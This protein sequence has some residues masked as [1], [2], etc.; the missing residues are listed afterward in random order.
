[1]ALLE[2]CQRLLH[3]AVLSG[4]QLPAEPRERRR[5][6]VN[7]ITA[8][9]LGFN[10]LLYVP[11]L[12][13]LGYPGLALTLLPQTGIYVLA[14][15]LNQRGRFTASRLVLVTLP[16]LAILAYGLRLGSTETSLYFALACLP[17]VLCDLRE[18]RIIAWGIALPLACAIFFAADGPARFGFSLLPA[19][20]AF[21][22]HL[23]LVPGTFTMLLGV[24]LFFVVSNSGAERELAT[25]HVTMRKLLARVDQG[26]ATLD[27]HGRLGPER[28]AVFDDWCGTPESGTLFSD[29]LRYLDPPVGEAFAAAWKVVESEFNPQASLVDLLAGLP[30]SLSTSE[31]LSIRLVYKPEREADGTLQTIMVVMTDVTNEAERA[32]AEQSQRDLQTELLQAQKLESVGRLASG[33]AHE[34]NTPI[35]FIGDSVQFVREVMPDLANV[36]VA[37][38]RLAEAVST[39]TAVPAD[40]A[41]VAEAEAKG[42]LDYALEQIPKA[43]D[44]AH[45]GVG[46][47]A[48]IVRSMK[49][50]AHP[51][52]VNKAPADLN[53]A[54]SSTLTVAGNAV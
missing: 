11:V 5:I 3:R 37:Y 19:K 30:S 53:A 48:A 9:A 51:D 38:R 24:I 39:G 15:W 41:S 7:N 27:R 35:Q 31:P 34:I 23:S 47:V 28:S 12:L 21:I 45:D 46:R 17:L 40:A 54:L 10:G 29:C 26:I 18:T 14:V 20:T 33:V 36:V 25:A 16:N 22:L 1:V 6:R 52:G 43:L 8:L 4:T 13:S 50:F 42:D 2:P 44:R 32:R 49:A